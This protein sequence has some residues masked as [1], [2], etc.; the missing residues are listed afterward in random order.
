[1]TVVTQE[2]TD[3]WRKRV[4]KKLNTLTRGHEELKLGQ[5]ELR[6]HIDTHAS[7]IQTNTTITATNTE[8]MLRLEKTLVER[9]LRTDPA[10]DFAG[11]ALYSV[12]VLTKLYNAGV[13]FVQ[14]MAVTGVGILAIAASIYFLN[15]LLT[16]KTFLSAFN[17]VVAYFNGTIP[18]P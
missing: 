2:I 18:A 13:W 17:I 16:G 15:L 4:D 10:I 11:K 12:T 3:G 6:K 5:I 14:S 8:T 7:M 9:F 1:M